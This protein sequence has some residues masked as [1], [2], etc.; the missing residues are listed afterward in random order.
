MQLINLN[1]L[2]R[3]FRILKIKYITLKPRK[4]EYSGIEIYLNNKHYRISHSRISGMYEITIVDFLNTFIIPFRNIRIH[5]LFVNNK[6]NILM[7][8]Y[9][10]YLD[11]GIQL[12][13]TY[14]INREST[15][16]NKLSDRIKRNNMK[17]F[18]LIATDK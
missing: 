9:I 6:S 4:H 14:H 12:D 11:I 15:K 13:L 1:E 3:I 5:E 18:F 7:G 2:K 8:F 16:S 10:N 17:D